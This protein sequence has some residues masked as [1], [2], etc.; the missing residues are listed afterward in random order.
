[1]LREAPRVGGKLMAV[2]A[3]ATI[4]FAVGLLDD[5]LGTRFPVLAKLGGQLV[6]ALVVAAGDVRISI[7][8]AEWMNVVLTVVWIVGMTN[9]FNL[10]DNMDGLA[11]GV[12]L[13]AS[14]V[15]LLNAWFLGEL[16]IVLLLAAFMG[17]LGGFL[18]HNAPPARVFLG[19]CG[20][21]F[22]GCTMGS[23]TLLERYVSHASSSLFPV[24]M[25]VVVLA[26]PLI[27]TLTVV[28]VRLKE[29]RPVYVGDRLHL[30]HR[31]VAHGLSPRAAVIFLYLATIFLGLG[32]V[33]L[34]HAGPVVSVLVLVQTAGTVGLLLWLLFSRKDGA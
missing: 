11:S 7:L 32:A 23:L 4:C 22:L 33:T 26:V 13:A 1:M 20:S 21:L 29:R 19:D 5:V 28:V 34:A 14:L 27:D 9:A 2:L 17:S 30:S 16:F 25:P 24:L 6:A 18:L 10:L 3:G 15:F 12:G 31:L 8:P